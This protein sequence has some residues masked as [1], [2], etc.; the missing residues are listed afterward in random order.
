LNC[1]GVTRGTGELQFIGNG[2]NITGINCNFT[3]TNE[4]GLSVMPNPVYFICGILKTKIYKTTLSAI[5]ANQLLKS[6]IFDENLTLGNTPDAYMRD[7]DKCKWLA[8]KMVRLG[9]NPSAANFE[10]ST[11]VKLYTGKKMNF[12]YRDFD[13]SFE[14]RDYN[15]YAVCIPFNPWS[16][17][18]VKV[19]YSIAYRVMFSDC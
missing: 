15:L 9:N 11:V 10:N 12:R 18:D 19:N 13:T 7:T 4:S 16:G 5:P 2:Y 3:L 1:L 6:E 14:G 8:Y 17:S